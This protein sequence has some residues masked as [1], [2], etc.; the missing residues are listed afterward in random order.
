MTDTVFVGDLPDVFF[1]V[2][3]MGPQ[4]QLGPV[5]PDVFGF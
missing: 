4:G 1:F 3:S 2:V 5:R